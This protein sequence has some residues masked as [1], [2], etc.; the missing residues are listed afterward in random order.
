MSA[1]CQAGFD[2]LDVFPLTASYEPGALDV[3]HYKDEVFYTAEVELEKY[4]R[5]PR[6]E[7]KATAVCL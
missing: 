2:V 4:A 1:M 5:T 7:Y 6:Q 3:V